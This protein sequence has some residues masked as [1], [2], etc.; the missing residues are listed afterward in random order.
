MEYQNQSSRRHEWTTYRKDDVRLV[1]DVSKGGWGDVH[2][3]EVEDPIAG[4][5]D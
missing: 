2:D 5:G 3:H 1:A 4:R